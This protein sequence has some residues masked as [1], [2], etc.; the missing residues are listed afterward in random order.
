[1]INRKFY[2]KVAPH[3]CATNLLV[4]VA[5]STSGPKI[6]EHYR[7][8]R[9]R[10]DGEGGIRLDPKRAFD[11]DQKREICRRFEGK[12]AICGELV[13]EGDDEYDHFPVAYRDGGRTV[14]ENGRLVC[15]Q[16]HPRG[17]P[18]SEDDE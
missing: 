2:E 1:M 17:R 7:L 14:I 5:R 10:V 8:W 4:S 18:Q 15:R 11:E 16:H 3:L 6:A 12:C 13:E 9:E